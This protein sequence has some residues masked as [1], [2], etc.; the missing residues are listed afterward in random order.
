MNTS[1]LWNFKIHNQTKRNPHELRVSFQEGCIQDNYGHH[2]A[3]VDA[4]LD[5]LTSS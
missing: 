4:T 3:A 2:E 1:P 5:S